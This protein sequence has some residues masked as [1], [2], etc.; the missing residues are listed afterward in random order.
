MLS[1][2]ASRPLLGLLESDPEGKAPVS[3]I[4]AETELLVKAFT[5]LASLV[6]HQLSRPK[7]ALETL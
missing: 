5:C 3:A 7:Q 6:E 1:V 4:L 2:H